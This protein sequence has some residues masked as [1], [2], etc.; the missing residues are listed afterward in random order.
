MS[1]RYPPDEVNRPSIMLL[2]SLANELA[3]WASNEPGGYGGM[4][5]ERERLTE[6]LKKRIEDPRLSDWDRDMI[7][8]L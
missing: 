3:I 5:L 7:R 8:S 4:K 1:L 2:R 6:E